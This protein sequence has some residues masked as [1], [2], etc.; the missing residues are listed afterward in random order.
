LLFTNK[1]GRKTSAFIFFVLVCCAAPVLAA[2]SSVVR[3]V[4]DGDTLILEDGRKVRLIG[5][6]TPEMS[7]G[8]RNRR[9]AAW[10]HLSAARVDDFALKAK[11][12]VRRQIE[13]K[14]VRLEY[15]WQKMD[16]YGRLLAYVTREPDGFFLN[17]E[18][19]RQG[20]GFDYQA[21]AFKYSKEFRSYRREAQEQKRGLW[22]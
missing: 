12:F 21:F 8:S 22:N 9:N 11:E 13:G 17:A 16:K 10:N 7:D 19:I 2:D 15:D 14:P 20:Y 5:V 1:G 18:I 6:D 4:A 3:H